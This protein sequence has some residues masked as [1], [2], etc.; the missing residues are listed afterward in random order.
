MLKRTYSLAATLLVVHE[1]DSAFWQEWN[2][3]GLPGGV[4]LFLAVHVAMVWALLWGHERVLL[5]DRA[6]TWMS[7]LLGLS[8]VA[9]ALIHGSFLLR[10]ADAFRTPASLAVLGSTLVVSLVLLGAAFFGPA[11]S[12]RTGG[13]TGSLRGGSRVAS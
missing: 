10:G 7:V 1:I 6:G 11:V 12:R 5:G 8:G 13:E 9:T 3:F 2:L 4:S